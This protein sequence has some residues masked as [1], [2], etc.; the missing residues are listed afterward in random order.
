MLPDRLILNACRRAKYAYRQR[1]FDPVVTVFHFLIQAIQREHS[2]A[3]TWAELWGAVAV[4]F[5]L[6]NQRFNSSAMSQARSRLP[7]AVVEILTR[8]ACAVDEIPCECW[9]GMRLKALD[10]STVSMPRE[11]GLFRHFGA[12]KARTTTVRYPLGTVCF[13]LRVGSSLIEDYRFGPF[14]P[15][16]KDTATPL[17]THLGPGD[18]LLADRGF[19]GSPT[20][21]RLLAR[22]AH[23]LMR[24]NARLIVSRLTIVKRL[25]PHDFIVELPVS[26]PARKADP[27]L[28]SSIRVRVFRATWV[29]PAGESLTEWFVTS[30]LDRKAFPP[31]TLANLYH[32]RWRIETSYEEFKVLFHADVLRSKTVDNIYKE[33]AA[34]VLA[35]QLVRRLIRQAAVTHDLSPTAISFLHATRWILSFSSRMSVSPPECLPAMYARLLDAIASTPVDVRPGRIEPRA[36]TREWKHYP[37]LRT[38]RSE[39]RTQR[40]KET[41]KCLS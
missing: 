11:A 8:G 32:R 17:L 18:L 29:S 33:M 6:R 4:A 3:A 2:F 31:R 39:W 41:N 25:G 9:R 36:L 1:V 21:A 16:E 5:G 24:K 30:L 10:G 7:Q 20:L 27:S 23:F 40:L 13:L 34:H 35:Y 19:A 14:D 22:D 15:G 26:K 12:H 38:T 37:H 28:P